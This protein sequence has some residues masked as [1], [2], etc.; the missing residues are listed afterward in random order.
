M[1]LAISSLVVNFAKFSL[2]AKFN[3]LSNNIIILVRYFLFNFI[4]ICVTVRLFN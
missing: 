1:K 3:V 2:A 4:N